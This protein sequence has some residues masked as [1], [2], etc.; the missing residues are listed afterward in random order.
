[1]PLPP[2]LS[3][4]GSRT[5]I[6]RGTPRVFLFGWMAADGGAEEKKIFGP[7]TM[8]SHLVTRPGSI[9]EYTAQMSCCQPNAYNLTRTA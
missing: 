8:P 5:E 9:S 7:A 2:K 1:M 4:K 3:S 6:S